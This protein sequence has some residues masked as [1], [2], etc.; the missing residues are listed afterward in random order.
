MEAVHHD[1]VALALTSADAAGEHEVLA[2]VVGAQLVLDQDALLVV[3]EGA[4]GWNWNEMGLVR[5]SRLE[6]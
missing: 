2:L 1:D 4:A 6:D 5:K 3:H